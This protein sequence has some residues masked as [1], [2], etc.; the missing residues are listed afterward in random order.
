MASPPA[1]PY[2]PAPGG[3]VAAAPTFDPVPADRR[4]VDHRVESGDSLWKLARAYGTSVK[5]IRDANQLT[6]DMILAGQTIRIPT[7]LPEG[8]SPGLVAPPAAA[9]DAA[10]LPPAPGAAPSSPA[11][12]GSTADLFR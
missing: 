12:P 5:E 9:S 11:S 4:I 2:A 10:G 1:A 7:T 3:V 8:A 6:G